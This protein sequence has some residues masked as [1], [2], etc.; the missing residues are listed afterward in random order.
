MLVYEGKHKA[1]ES[2]KSN[3][4]ENIDYQVLTQKGEN[5][6]G[7]RPQSIYHL[8]VSCLEYFI[9]R[10]IRPVFEVYRLVFHSVAKPIQNEAST[11][12]LAQRRKATGK[13]VETYLPNEDVLRLQIA[14]HQEWYSSV[15]HLMQCLVYEFL[16]NPYSGVSEKIKHIEQERNT[17]KNLY[18]G[19]CGFLDEILPMVQQMNQTIDKERTLR[20]KYE[21]KLKQIKAAI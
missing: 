14:A 15:Y 3:F 1:V 5:P 16:E 6:K 17:W 2:L 13:R 8:S 9:A 18:L 11:Y 4:I 21:N 10:K 12:P 20:K 19:R 7:G